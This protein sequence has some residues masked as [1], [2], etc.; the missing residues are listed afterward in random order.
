MIRYNVHDQ[1]SLG[2]PVLDY[3]YV[4]YYTIKLLLQ[5]CFPTLKVFTI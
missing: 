1:N 5:L 2:N 3:L 4:Q